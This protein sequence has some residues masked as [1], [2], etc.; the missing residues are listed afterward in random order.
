M[1]MQ[2]CLSR[3]DSKQKKEC[4]ECGPRVGADITTTFDCDNIKYLVSPDKSTTAKLIS[5]W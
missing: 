5:S 4:E 2:F 1:S 3:L